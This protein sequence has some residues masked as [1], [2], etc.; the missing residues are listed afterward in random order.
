MICNCYCEDTFPTSEGSLA[1]G[2]SC[3]YL[4]SFSPDS[5]GTFD[6]CVKVNLC[7]V[8]LLTVVL[9]Y[10]HTKVVS[11]EGVCLTVPLLGRRPQPL[12]EGNLTL[13]Y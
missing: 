7:T 12:L 5:I 8:L 2:I 4:V 6:D 10:L 1:P 3:T 11:H 9:E 13:L